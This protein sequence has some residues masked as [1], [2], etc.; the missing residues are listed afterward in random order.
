MGTSEQTRAEDRQFISQCNLLSLQKSLPLKWPTPAEIPS[1]P[2]KSYRSAYVYPWQTEVVDPA[3][4]MAWK[5]LSNFDLLLRLVD[6]SGLRPVL[7]HLLGWRSGRGWEPFDPVSFFLL[8]AWQISHQWTRSQTLKNMHDGRYADDVAWFGF[9]KGVY[10]TE[11]GVRYFLTTLGDNSD[12][13]NET[14]SVEKGEETVMIEVQKLNML[15]AEAVGVMRQTPILRACEF[16]RY[17]PLRQPRSSMKRQV[18]IGSGACLGSSVLYPIALGHDF[19]WITW[20][21]QFGLLS[22]SPIGI[23]LPPES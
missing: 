22:H 20:S 15:L 6:F 11:G 3:Q 23:M 10:P 19:G 14:I 9:Q 17:P 8:V 12:A 1:S 2:K 5:N 21:R 4:V 18:E 13:S 16:I 7:A